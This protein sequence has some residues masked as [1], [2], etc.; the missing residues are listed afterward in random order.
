MLK[1]GYKIIDFKDNN[2]TTE[3]PVVITGIY[4][5]LENNYRKPLLISGI[6]IDGVEKPDCFVSCTHAENSYTFALYGHNVTVSNADS[7]SI[8]VA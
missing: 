6:T 5:E 8:A 4:S 1:G 3:T 7:V 2:L